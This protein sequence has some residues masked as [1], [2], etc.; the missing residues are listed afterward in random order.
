MVDMSP[1]V[2]TKRPDTLK[3]QTEDSKKPVT[4][5]KSR[6]ERGANEAAHKA[7]QREQEFDQ[8]HNTISK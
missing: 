3:Q 2:P 5:A 4:G 8:N 1:K 6:A 7:A